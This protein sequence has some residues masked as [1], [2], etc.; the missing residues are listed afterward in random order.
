MYDIRKNNYMN[1]S[2]LYENSYL[3]MPDV[4]WT[5]VLGG[6]GVLSPRLHS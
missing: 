6:Y 1:T 2:I 5:N 4:I 3:W